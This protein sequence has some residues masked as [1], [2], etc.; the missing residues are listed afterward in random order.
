MDVWGASMIINDCVLD[1]ENSM[2]VEPGA[3]PWYDLSHYKNHGTITGATWVQLPSGLWVMDL[4]GSDFVNIPDSDSMDIG[5]SDF[6]VLWWQNI[7]STAATQG[8]IDKGA[9]AGEIG[10]NTL[11][12]GGTGRLYLWM[13]DDI[14]ARHRVTSTPSVTAG[15]W[16][17]MAVTV[18][19]DVGGVISFN[20]VVQ[21]EQADDL[22][23]APDSLANAFDATIGRRGAHGGYFTGMMAL[24]RIYNY[25]LTAGQVLQRYEK[26]R[27]LLGVHD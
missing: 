13:A 1:L 22:A 25:A 11:I 19:R 15:I 16:Q 8:L 21:G 24:F 20:A 6:T 17:L 14:V 9:F 3:T 27:Y 26:T 23:A 10:W 4:D 18:D 5:T 12:E 7:T 2:D